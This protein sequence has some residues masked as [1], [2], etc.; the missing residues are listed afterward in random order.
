MSTSTQHSDD[1]LERMLALLAQILVVGTG[2]TLPFP[3]YSVLTEGG[4]SLLT[5]DSFLLLLE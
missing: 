5:E 3:F 4:D 2:G 1:L